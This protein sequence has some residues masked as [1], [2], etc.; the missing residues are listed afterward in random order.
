[1]AITRMSVVGAAAVMLTATVGVGFAATTASGSSAGQAE[2]VVAQ[3]RGQAATIVGTSGADEIEGTN[4][5]DVIAGLAGNDDIEARGGNDLV[6]AGAGADDAEG[7]G[8]A[9]RI[10][11]N[12][13]N[14]KL[15]GDRGNDRLVGGPGFDKAEGDAGNDVCL[16][17][18]TQRC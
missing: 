12:R 13:G 10:F 3:C 4:G 16:A 11:G 17:E 18:V 2:R 8:G 14:D 5:R 7:K 1:M 6:C 15:E 9:D